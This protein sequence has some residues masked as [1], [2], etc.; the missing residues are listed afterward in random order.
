MKRTLCAILSAVFLSMLVIPC[1]AADTAAPIIRDY[2][3]FS[4]VAQD[5]WCYD[6]VKLCYEAGLMNGRTETV[7]DTQGDLSAAQ[8]VVL[9]ARLYDLRSGRQRE[10]PLPAGSEPA[11]SA[12]LRRERDAAPVVYADG[13][14]GVQRHDG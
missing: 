7:F 10:H 14:P 11:L 8:L 3:G 1:A 5:S 12:L 9:A 4:D 2:P 6:A 13:C